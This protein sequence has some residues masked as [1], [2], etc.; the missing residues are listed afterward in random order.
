MT[1][2]LSRLLFFRLSVSLSKGQYTVTV[3]F[4]LF[5][6]SHSFIA[7]SKRSSNYD[8][9]NT[10]IQRDASL[11]DSSQNDF[12]DVDVHFLQALH[13]CLHERTP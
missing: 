2:E 3:S 4:V 9:D 11:L 8:D 13:R 6:S 12:S 1:N 7:R 10:T 5:S